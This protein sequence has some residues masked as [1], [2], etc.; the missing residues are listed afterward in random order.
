MFKCEWCDEEIKTEEDGIVYEDDVTVCV[1]C[2]SA[3]EAHAYRDALK[4]S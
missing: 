3:V 2:Y 1:E 4:A